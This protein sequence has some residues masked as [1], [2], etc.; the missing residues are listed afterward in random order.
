M[1]ELPE[2]YQ[3]EMKELLQDEYASY[4]A[5]FA[6][7]CFHGLRVNT[8]KI[9]VSEFLALFPYPLEPVPWCENGFYYRA[10]DPVAKHPYYYA[11]LYY[12]QEP[13]AML[14]AAVLPIEK[15]DCVL[16][17]C[18]APGGKSTELGTKLAGTGLLFA[19]DI[20]VS[21]SH[22]LLRNIERFGIANAFVMAEDPQ[23]LEGYFP[24]YFDKILIDAPCSGEGMFRK[25]NSLIRSWMEN[26]S[27]HYVPIQKEI[28]KCCLAM[29]KDGGTMVYSTCTFSPQEDEEIIQYAC[30][31]D[32]SLHIL[33]IRK[34]DGFVQNAYGTK[35]FPHRIHGEGHFVCLL[36]KGTAKKANDDMP[37]IIWQRAPVHIE[38]PI[39]KEEIIND[40]HLFVPACGIDTKGIRILRSGLLL[41]EEKKDRFE[42]DGA[43]AMALK[44]KDC[45]N[46]LN[47]SA[48]DERAIR[49][50]KGETLDISD[51]TVKD[52]Y[53]LV[54]VDAQPLGFAKITHHVF[55]NKYP[56]G[57]I[58]H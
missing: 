34:T 40:K 44:E 25:E 47:F 14:P 46:V 10:A 32:P 58:Y 26:G 15:N 4:E 2:T 30:S 11:G 23:K 57:W 42:F 51:Q 3:R 17:V 8:D 22:A 38:L 55:K 12:I 6:Q 39:G 45:D 20:S 35:L 24:H 49:Y 5:S 56:K 19:N 41:G 28:V 1:I 27:S 29:L 21:R 31:L 16:D 52:G 9:S 7:P 33:P 37:S 36:Q 18:A 50:L 48:A 54:C 43:L 13:S 53:A